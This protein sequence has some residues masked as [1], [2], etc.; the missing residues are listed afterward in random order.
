VK[1]GRP[2]EIELMKRLYGW[3]KQ[4]MEMARFM[5]FLRNGCAVF[6]TVHG[7]NG[8]IRSLDFWDG[9]RLQV[10]D[11]AAAAHI[12]AEIFLGRCYDFPEVRTAHQIVDVGANIGLFSYFA[13][14]KNPNAKII[15]IEADPHTM[16]VL[17]TNVE[18]KR[19]EALH[20]A[21]SDRS[22]IVKFYSSSVSGWSS[23]Y[24]VRGA[25]GGEQVHV[26]TIRLSNLLRDRGI[27]HIGVLKID[28]EGAEYSILL[29]DRG[30]LEI[31]ID[32]LLVEVD[33]NPRDTRYSYDQLYNLLQHSFRHVMVVNSGSDYPLI[34]ATQGRVEPH[35]IH[36]HT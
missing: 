33:R 19:I 29:G 5:R 9:T 15:A 36:S 10:R 1:I 14:R 20:Y 23:L 22:G 17:R 3:A 25:I 32:A 27:E 26:P 13:R 35:L 8:G 4:G 16:K 12:F 31:P 6:R 2:S 30:L 28:V 18:G 21:A 7:S 34:Y 24:G 11:S